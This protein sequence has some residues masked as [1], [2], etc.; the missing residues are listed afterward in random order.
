V[1]QKSTK[2]R[3]AGAAAARPEYPSTNISSPARP[4]P[5]RT[6]QEYAFDED[7]DDAFEVPV[8]RKR[9]NKERRYQH[10][11]F[12]R[13]DDEDNSALEEFEPRRNSRPSMLK[14]NRPLG[15]PIT[16]D[17]GLAG[18]DSAQRAILDNFM[19]EAKGIAKKIQE[20][21]MF[22]NR[23]FS[24]TV[25]RSMGIELPINDDELL[26]IPGIEPEM[27]KLFSKR[28]LPLIRRTRNFYGYNVPQRRVLP[29][30]ED[31]EDQAPL[32][33]NHQNVIEL[34]SDS[35][36]G[37]GGHET[38]EESEFNFEDDEE[39]SEHIS[40][41]FMPTPVDPRVEEYNRRAT[42]L[43]AEKLAANP[44][45]VRSATKA[46]STRTT[47][48]TRKLPWKKG[49]YRRKSGNSSR[50][51]AGV[52]KGTA[53]K[54]TTNGG[55]SSFGSTKRSSGNGSRGGGGPSGGANGSRGHAWSSIMAMP[56]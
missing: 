9:A 4:H 2:K 51:Y 30:E 16:T 44:S 17:E 35:E 29:Q 26:M 54:T 49:S 40:P 7:E 15:R 1:A 53:K 11:N 33:P 41:H 37:M 18:L 52:K 28:F 46:P 23:P 19:E 22:R 36:D 12:V 13:P 43:E 25:L 34:S 6:I 39:E 10:D 21:K 42:Q 20:S 5:K 50:A 24:D 3:A 48:S 56:T 55:S 31:D 32:D 45:R 27:A 47:A 14:R 38:E 8:Q